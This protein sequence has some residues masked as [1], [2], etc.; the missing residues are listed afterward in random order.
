MK[1]CVN[2]TL[3]IVQSDVFNHSKINTVIC[4]VVTS[5][6]KLAE[7]PGNFI[8]RSNA[9]GLSK[10]SVVNVSQVITIDKSFLIEKVGSLGYKNIIKLD[11]GL[12]L[13]LAI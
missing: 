8:L 12:K 9:S 3:T 7:A 4:A 10:D 2:L 6:L 13:L 5:N 1:L 11:D